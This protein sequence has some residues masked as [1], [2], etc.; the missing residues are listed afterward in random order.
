K[1]LLPLGNM[2]VIDAP[3]T[4]LT[5]IPNTTTNVLNGVTNAVADHADPVTVFPL[6]ETGYL[7]PVILRAGKSTFVYRALINAGGAIN[8]TAQ[9]A[10]Y[11]VSA[12]NV[13]NSP[14]NS[15]TPPVVNF[16]DSGGTVQSSYASG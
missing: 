14:T 3:P 1:G 16:T 7:I 8:N 15:V 4:N 6:D 11:N 10:G 9:A 5:Y 2:V 12:Q 13:V